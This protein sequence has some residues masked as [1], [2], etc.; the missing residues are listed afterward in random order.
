MASLG[1]FGSTWQQAPGARDNLR[2]NQTLLEAFGAEPGNLTLGPRGRADEAVATDGVDEVPR[3]FSMKEQPG[4]GGP[5]LGAF[6]GPS[7]SQDFGWTGSSTGFRFSGFDG[8]GQQHLLRPGRTGQAEGFS[9]GTGLIS[10][11]GFG[12]GSGSGDPC[13]V[14]VFGFPGRMAAAVRQQLESLCGPILEVRHGEG[15][16]MHVRFQGPQAASACLA[17]NGQILLGQL[18][19]GCVPCAHSALLA[20]D[21]DAAEEDRGKGAAFPAGSI[22][23]AYGPGGPQVRRGG[24]LWRLLDNLFG[25]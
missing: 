19:V 20:C 4:F 9:P 11:G 1:V 21:S 22:V 7:S 6:R 24:L 14:T 12:L 3:I 13:W 16:F 15:N 10:G 5:L 17:L 18:M 23:P 2:S 25:I 8:W